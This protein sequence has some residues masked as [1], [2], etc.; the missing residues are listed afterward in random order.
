MSLRRRIFLQ[1]NL[2]LRVELRWSRSPERQY[3]AEMAWVDSPSE[4][5]SSV[6]LISDRAL[7]KYAKS[8]LYGKYCS[9]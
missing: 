7:R 9:E 2:L 1:N 5:C 8:M 3:S 6:V 4:S